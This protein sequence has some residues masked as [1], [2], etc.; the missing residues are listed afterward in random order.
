MESVTYMN[1]VLSSELL[2]L[3]LLVTEL[4]LSAFAAL[5]DVAQ[6][7]ALLRVAL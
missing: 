7:Q 6:L 4:C 1:L 2:Q 3:S 5:L